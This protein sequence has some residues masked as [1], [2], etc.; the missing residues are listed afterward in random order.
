MA[1][2]LYDFL[3]VDGKLNLKITEPGIVRTQM[4][5]G[6][7]LFLDS[8]T[9]IRRAYKKAKE[10]GDYESAEKLENVEITVHT[11]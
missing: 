1:H 6:R 3:I 5:G 2:S 7:F 4:A 9:L 8:P 10:I 11:E